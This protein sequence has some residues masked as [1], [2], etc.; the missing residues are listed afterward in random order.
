MAH[1]A[2]GYYP[3][4]DWKNMTESLVRILQT[5]HTL[6]LNKETQKM[7]EKRLSKRER[8]RDTARERERESSSGGGKNW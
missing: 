7:D 2:L 3:P 8:E 1:T 4:R 6:L 5:T